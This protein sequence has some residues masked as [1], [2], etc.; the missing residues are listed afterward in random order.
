MWKVEQ[1]KNSG[2]MGGVDGR[3]KLYFCII[4]NNI[5]TA[6]FCF[7]LAQKNYNINT[8]LQIAQIL[9]VKLQSKKIA[10]DD[11]D[12]HPPPVQYLWRGIEKVQRTL[13]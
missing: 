4:P 7:F 5:N 10:E 12:R 9:F 3:K 1:K 2:K 8:A 6:L 13:C 11:D